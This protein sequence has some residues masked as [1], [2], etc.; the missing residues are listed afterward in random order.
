MNRA[1]A[2]NA[3]DPVSQVTD[4]MRPPTWRTWS[5]GLDNDA[6]TLRDVL[7]T[8]PAAPPSAIP[9]IVRLFENRQGWL[10]LHGAVNLRSHDMIHVL[11]GRGQP[12]LAR[13]PAGGCRRTTPHQSMGPSI[14]GRRT[15]LP[16]ALR[17]W[18]A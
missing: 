14:D 10:R 5:P 15:P 4:V 8:L 16:R 2:K 17:P 12:C 6:L 18:P 1:H 9:W 13:R 11:L 3:A 7:A